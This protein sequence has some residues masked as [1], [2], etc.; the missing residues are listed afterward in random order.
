MWASQCQVWKLDLSSVGIGESHV[1]EDTCIFNPELQIECPFMIGSDPL[2]QR[3]SW[4]IPVSM[5]HFTLIHFF[6][7]LQVARALQLKLET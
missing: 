1:T 3:S 6:D 4:R 2:M 7:S 5:I